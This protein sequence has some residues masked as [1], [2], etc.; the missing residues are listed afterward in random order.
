MRLSM[1]RARRTQG[2]AASVV[3]AGAVQRLRG[4]A[5]DQAAAAA[6][7][8]TFKREGAHAVPSA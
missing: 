5:A 3:A 7:S 2:R 1:P 6:Y 4:G 8:V